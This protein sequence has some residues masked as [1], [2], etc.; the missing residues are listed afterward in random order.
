MTDVLNNV[1]SVLNNPIVRQGLM[2]AAPEIALGI[3]LVVT[4]TKGLFGSRKHSPSALE[5]ITI[6]DKRLAELLQQLATTKSRI[7]RSE[8]EIRVHEL[9]GI[10]NSISKI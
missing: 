8:L 7:M 1:Q 3:D 5:L 10:L 2:I 6:I 9:L 4:I